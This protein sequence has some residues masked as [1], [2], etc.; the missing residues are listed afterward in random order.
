MNQG[1]QAFITL[2]VGLVTWLIFGVVASM[3]GAKKGAGC[4]GFILGVLLG[5]IG[6]VIALVMKGNRKACPY[7]KELINVAAT[8]CSK[9][10]KDVT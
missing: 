1:E 6:I 10:Q 3:I 4:S 8:V 7:C 5:P 9:C 2:T